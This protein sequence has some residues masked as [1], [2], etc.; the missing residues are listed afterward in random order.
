MWLE[1]SIQNILSKKISENPIFWYQCVALVKYFSSLV[2]WIN[3]WNFD[4]SAKTGFSN[5]WAFD[6]NFFDQK[7]YKSWV[8]PKVWS[9]IFFDMFWAFWH[10]GVVLEANSQNFLILEQNWALGTATWEWSDA[11]RKKIYD[12]KKVLGWREPRFSVDDMNILSFKNQWFSDWKNLNE[13]LTR[14]QAVVILI[15]IISNQ[16]LNYQNT[17]NLAKT[18]KVFDW[19]RENIWVTRQ[20]LAI[21]IWRIFWLDYQKTIQVW[22]WNWKDESKIA[23]RLEWILMILRAKNY[24]FVNKNFLIN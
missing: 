17:I 10:T 16:S 23:S 6:K 4:W 3:L 9:I 15:R 7:F 11:I 14:G 1:K 5:P 8:V 2:F 12:Y 20:E 24:N 21:M 13:I 18:K 22:I 19:T